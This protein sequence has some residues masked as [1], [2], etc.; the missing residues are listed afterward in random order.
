MTVYTEYIFCVVIF[1]Y[2]GLITYNLKINFTAF[3]NTS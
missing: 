1:G 3:L 2:I